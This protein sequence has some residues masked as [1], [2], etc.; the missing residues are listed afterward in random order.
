MKRGRRLAE[1][2]DRDVY[3]ICNGVIVAVGGLQGDDVR[4][5]RVVGATQVAAQGDGDL[6]AAPE[7]TVNVGVPVETC[8]G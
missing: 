7:I 1:D 4:L 6:L 5:V 3:H 2:D 8:A